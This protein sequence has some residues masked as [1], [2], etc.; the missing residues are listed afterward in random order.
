MLR[1]SM[2]KPLAKLPVAC[3]IRSQRLGL[4]D[5]RNPAQ[6]VGGPNEKYMSALNLAGKRYGKLVALHPG[7][8]THKSC[9]TW[10]CKCDC[11]EI[12]T[13]RTHRLVSGSTKSCGC[14]RR[15]LSSMRLRT[16]GISR[17]LTGSSW[18]MMLNRCFNPK[19]PAFK[20]YGAKGI[21]ACEY[22]RATP[23]NMV[24]LI[25][26]RPS[27]DYS[28]DRIKSEGSY[29]CGVCAE[30]LSHGWPL[31]VRWATLE[32]QSRNRSSTHNVDIGGEVRCIK[33][34]AEFLGVDRHMLVKKLSKAPDKKSL[35]LQ[36]AKEC[37]LTGRFSLHWEQAAER[38]N[39]L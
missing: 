19:F 34:W 17:S 11:G 35:S 13:T 3:Y 9:S 4:C 1:V 30:C 20:K 38:I 28:I 15:E 39:T 8:K 23:V 32:T 5:N 22:L 10:V 26:E 2:R 16:H 27:K 29:S 31:N 37:L 12:I 25:G 21:T 6:R 36:Q 7:E 33:D 18:S 14:L 24:M